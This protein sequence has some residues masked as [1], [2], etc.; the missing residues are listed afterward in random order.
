MW[1]QVTLKQ[2]NAI[3]SGAEDTD[4]LMSGAHWLVD[5]AGEDKELQRSKIVNVG[6]RQ[7]IWNLQWVNEFFLTT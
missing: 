2:V 7:L 1:V 3:G 4:W 5:A 6:E